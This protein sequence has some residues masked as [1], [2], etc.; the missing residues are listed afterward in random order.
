M[1]NIEKEIQDKKD[2]IR[3]KILSR[4]FK[5]GKGQYGEG[6]IFLGIVVPVQRIIA[7][8]H[9]DISLKEVQKLLNSKIHEYRLIA[10]FIL[11]EKYKEDK[12]LIYN[13]YIKNFRNI[14]NWDL[15]DLT[16]PKIM[17]DF[18]KY[19]NRDILYS[20]AISNDLWERRI[21]IIA[22]FAFIKDN[23]FKD[24]LKISKILLNDKHDLIHKAVGWML[25][26]IGK[27]D[28]E[29]EKEFLN[30][31]Y[32]FMPRTMLRYSIEKFNPREKEFYMK[33]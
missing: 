24:A 33:K 7:K 18:L 31:Y 27:R 10:L 19:K 17:G 16:A 32:R 11:I 12:E 1:V 23:D 6:D 3:A 15:V 20:L 25:R 29:V 26:E 8:K 4:F 14:N 22:T 30:K 13:K 21:S 2:P 28:K 9:K 5:T